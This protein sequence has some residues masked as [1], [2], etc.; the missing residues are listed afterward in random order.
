VSEHIGR[1]FV[2]V[3]P[4]APVLDAIAEAVAA[5]GDPPPGWRWTAREQWHI[6]LQF[7]GRVDDVEAVVAAMRD[8]A[9]AHVGFDARLG[10]AGAFPSARRAGVVWA[11]VSEGAD[12]LGDLASSVTGALG[13]LGFERE[14]G[15]FHPH[16]TVARARGRDRRDA[17]A[18]VEALSGAS[19]GERFRVGEIVLFESRTRPT[20]A[21]YVARARVPLRLPLEGV[22]DA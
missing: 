22:E 14:E 4:P 6:T 18:L 11:G 2:A 15:R 8:A 13:A 10:G 19:A 9:G 16:L 17:R 7:L 1:A 20:G 3:V 5:A 21:E 12:A